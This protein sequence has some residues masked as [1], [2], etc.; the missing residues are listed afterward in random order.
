MIKDIGQLQAFL[1]IIDT[2]SLGRA[3]EVLCVTQSAL[4]RIIQRLEEQVGG[5]LFERHTRGMT[6]TIYGRALEPYA[7]HLVAETGNA[8]AEMDA[9]RGLRTGQVRVGAVSSALETVLPQ[10]IDQLLGQWPGLSISIAEAMTDEL[11]AMLLKNEIDLAVAF[12]LSESDE[13][14]LVAESSWQVGCH[15]VA[16]VDHPLQARAGLR[17]EDVVQE[18]WALPPKKT[19]PREEW[20]QV[21][22]KR[23]M[24]APLPAAETRSVAAMRSLVSNCGFLSWLP[25]TL[26]KPAGARCNIRPLVIEGVHLPRHFAVYRRRH[27]ILSAPAAKLID[28]LRVVVRNLNSGA[29]AD[30]GSEKS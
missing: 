23:G 4:T 26:L 11:A 29:C 3:A 15:I 17:L 20:Q 14:A 5:H 1:A 6:P 18:K 21:F 28:E 24:S 2:G 12:S 22:V 27:G 8:M 19:G 13:L 30:A 16:A 7:I 10:A 25:D 9:L